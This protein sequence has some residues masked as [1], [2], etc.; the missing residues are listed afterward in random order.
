MCVCVS[1][2]HSV[3]PKFLLTFKEEG[4]GKDRV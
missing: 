2:T 4:V 1:K 3:T